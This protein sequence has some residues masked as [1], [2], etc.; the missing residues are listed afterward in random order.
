MRPTR[1]QAQILALLEQ[2][3][4]EISAQQLYL[5]LREQKSPIGL[6]TV[7]RVLKSLH[8][9]GIIQ[10]RVASTGE[11][12]YSLITKTHYHHLNCIH[13]GESIAME[14]CPITQQLT[15]WCKSQNFKVYYHTL[16][17]FGLCHTCQDEVME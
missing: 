7:Y 12:F 6:A 2:I 14:D 3:Q 13:C 8:L 17:F 11:S 1:N 10:E 5:Q 15:Q 16:E 4:G 9:E